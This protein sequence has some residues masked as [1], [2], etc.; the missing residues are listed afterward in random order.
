MR[1]ALGGIYQESHIFSSALATL[2]QFRA[3]NLLYGED[4]VRGLSSRNHEIGGALETASGHTLIPLLYA[5]AGS[6]GQPLRRQTYDELAGGMLAR[7][8]KALPVDGVWMA[9]HGAMVA[10]HH[11]DATGHLLDAVRDMVGANVP[12]VATLDLHA[13]VTRWCPAACILS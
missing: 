12:V 7:L 13:N 5:S 1:I 9:M 6:S 4:L 11:D 10:E 8:Q 3:G 2:D